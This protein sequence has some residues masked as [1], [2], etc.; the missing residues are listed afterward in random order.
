MNWTSRTVCV[1]SLCL[2]LSACDG[3]SR[4]FAEAVEVRVNNLNGIV[5][6]PP[7]NSVADI[8]LNVDQLLQFSLDGLAA[9]GA[10]VPLE[11]SER[12]WRVSDSSVAT[13]SSDGLLRAINDGIVD[14]SVNLGGLTSSLFR[15]TVDTQLLLSINAINGVAS[16]E[17][18]RPQDYFATGIFADGSTRNLDGVSW[19][20]PGSDL[21]D[22]RVQANANGTAT[23]T[24]LNVSL[25]DLTATLGQATLGQS[26]VVSDTLRTLTVTPSPA[27]VDVGDTLA[28]VATGGYGAAATGG[29][30]PPPVTTQVIIS[31]Q[32]D[33]SIVDTDGEAA[34]TVSNTEGSRGQ[35]TGVTAGTANV[36]ASCG[37]AT[38]TRT[39]VV[40]DTSDPDS[41][42]ILSFNVGSP[43]NLSLDDLD[44]FSLRVS[45]GSSFAT[46]NEIT[47]EVTWSFSNLENTASPIGLVLTGVNAGLVTPLRLGTATVTATDDDGASITITIE[48]VGS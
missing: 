41:S 25:L 30:T 45:T 7:A 29:P 26:V 47:D 20:L 12:D 9:N 8:F 5:V 6:T 17:R 38:D 3:D 1:S 46:D 27:G 23:L 2:L 11:S 4:P 42:D 18:C 44:G 16:V 43:F 33:W 28:M 39:I 10:R 13:I 32:V 19:T 37:L 36:T 48:V 15:V 22:A 40:S 31:E 35:V 24:A 14:V 34:A 21:S